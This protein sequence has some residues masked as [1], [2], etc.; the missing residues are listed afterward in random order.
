MQIKIAAIIPA[1]LKST[2]YPG[3]ILLPIHGIPMI[4]HVRRRALICKKFSEVIV[5][6]CDYEIAEVVRKNGGKVVMTAENHISGTTRVAEAASSIDCSHVLL[7]QGDEPLLL[8]KHLESLIKFVIEEPNADVCNLVGLIESEDELDRAS[9]VK[10]SIGNPNQI[11]YCFRRTPSIARFHIQY[12]YIRKMLG[13]IAYRKDFLLKLA[14]MPA[15]PIEI[16]ESIEQMRIIENGFKFN[17]V[18]VYPSLP[19]INE[20]HELDEVLNCLN[21]NPE[22]IKLL[23]KILVK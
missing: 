8:P 18:E 12:N 9:F 15:T 2:R 1:R 23:K 4:E 6:T 20:P 22:Q 21:K 3:K 11:L 17:Y 13:V 7:L 14:N 16:S 19:S 5:A 10:C